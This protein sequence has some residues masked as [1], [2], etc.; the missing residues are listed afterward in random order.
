MN[1]MKF[2]L[3]ATVATVTSSVVLAQDVAYDLIN[4]SGYTVVEVFTSPADSGDW[5]PDILGTDV[6][7]SDYS[8]TVLVADNS[9]QC[10]Y[11]ILFVFDDGDELYDQI[12]VCDTVS[13]TL[14]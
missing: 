4:V 1:F 12:D 14:Q 5:G 6:L 13:Y 7:A 8:A 10:L 2:A 9:D 3:A 11:D